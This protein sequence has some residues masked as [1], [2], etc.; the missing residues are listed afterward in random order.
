M[1]EAAILQG[2]FKLVLALIGFT[3]A[4]ICLYWM[5]KFLV[6]E[7]FTL[8]LENANDNAKAIYYGARIIAIA[9]LIGLALS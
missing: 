2:S 5:D 4:R 8:W 6:P 7:K 3:M 1:L 9:L